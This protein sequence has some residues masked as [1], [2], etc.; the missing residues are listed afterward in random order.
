MR[1]WALGTRI[2]QHR[3]LYHIFHNV[4]GGMIII[5]IIVDLC[6]FILGSVNMTQY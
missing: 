6:I 3:I 1:Q 2:T 5:I 4:I